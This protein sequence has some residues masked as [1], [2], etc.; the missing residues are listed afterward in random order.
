MNIDDIKLI[1]VKDYKSKTWCVYPENIGCLIIQVDNLE[2]APKELAKSFQAI[3][4][5]GFEKGVHEIHNIDIT[6]GSVIP[7]KKY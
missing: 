5:Y 3:L 1:C 2:D 4:K 7:P 6:E